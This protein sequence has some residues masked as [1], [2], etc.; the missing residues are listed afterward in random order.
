[1]SRLFCETWGFRTQA[2]GICLSGLYNASVPTLTD[3]RLDCASAQLR[4]YEHPLLNFSARAKGEG[5]EIIIK[6]KDESVPVHIIIST[7]IPAISTT[8][9]SSGAFSANSSTHLHDYFME[10]FIRTPQD[11]ADRRQKGL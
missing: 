9:S 8:R 7:C 6:F 5:V 2:S 3:V 4:L 1:M 11:R 10:M